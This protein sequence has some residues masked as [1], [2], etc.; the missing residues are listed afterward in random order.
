MTPTTLS[1]GGVVASPE[2]NLAQ[3][4]KDVVLQLP[5]VGFDRARRPTPFGD[6]AVHLRQPQ[7]GGVGEPGHRRELAV[8]S[9][10]VRFCS[11]A[12]TFW[13]AWLADRP[14][15]STNRVKPSKSR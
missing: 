12:R 3:C 4:R 6:H 9:R 7:V 8:P 5:A 13:L 14:L 1:T 2:A 10:L 15:A 11:F